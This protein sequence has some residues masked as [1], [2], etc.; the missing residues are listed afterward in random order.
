[1]PR[2]VHPWRPA[3]THTV[4]PSVHDGRNW[5]SMAERLAPMSVPWVGRGA[6]SVDDEAGRG[7]GPSNS[8]ATRSS[9]RT[10]YRRNTGSA[11]RLTTGR[12]PAVLSA[13]PSSTS[14]THFDA[15]L[16]TYFIDV[17]PNVL[18]VLDAIRALLKPKRGVWIHIGPL[19]Y[20]TD[21]AEPLSYSQLR[22]LVVHAGFEILREETRT[23]EG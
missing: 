19:V 22:A 15:V 1:M 7:A 21:G 2:A 9:C 16:T 5:A 10:S 4:Y 11:V 23:C 3:S 13:S 17:V 14:P 20:P 8:R 18:D 12:F 6:E